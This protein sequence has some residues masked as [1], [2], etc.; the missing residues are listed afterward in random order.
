MVWRGAAQFGTLVRG[1]PIEA[2]LLSAE[3]GGAQS[4]SS[5]INV[6][7]MMSKALNAKSGMV[8]IA[9]LAATAIDP[10]PA[11]A[12]PVRLA[13]AFVANA[14]QPP[15]GLVDFFALPP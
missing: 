12:G 6:G 14:P 5:H 7:A 9:A 15:P 13:H 4:R 8:L 2:A 3:G 11:V 1:S 10:L